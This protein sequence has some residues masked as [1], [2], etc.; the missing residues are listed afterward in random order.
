MTTTPTGTEAGFDLDKLEAELKS[1]LR[2]LDRDY[3]GSVRESVDEIGEMIALA[4]RVAPATTDSESGDALPCPFCGG[5]CDPDGWLGGGGLRGPECENCGATADSLAGWN[6]RASLAPVSAQPDEGTMLH[7]SRELIAALKRLSFAAQTTGGTAGAD[8]ELQGAIAQAEKAL[9]IGAVARAVSASEVSPVSAQ[10]GAAEPKRR[11]IFSICDAYESG[12]GHGLQRDG[13]KSGAIF[14]NP[15]HGKAYEI[16]YEEGERRSQGAAKAPAAQAVSNRISDKWL[17]SVAQDAGFNL[18]MLGE[19]VVPSP[20][21]DATPYLRKFTKLLAA[22]PASTPEAAPVQ[23]QAAQGDLD[24]LVREYGNAP[25]TGPCRT[26]RVVMQ[27]IYRLAG[28]IFAATT[29]GAA[30]T[31]EDARDAARLDLL[32]DISGFHFEIIDQKEHL[33]DA[34]GRIAG[35]GATKREAIDAAMRATQQEGGN[36]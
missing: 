3:I 21:H 25:V 33:L 7:L 6:R 17:H 35:I 29:A 24:A 11:D 20:H 34:R 31:S 1:I 8:T 28:E 14:G 22:S 9:S 10:Q 5:K 26:R 13:H 19:L 18:N 23:Q 36:A 12:M 27:D 4:R 2:N 16:G 32:L 30:T 15:E